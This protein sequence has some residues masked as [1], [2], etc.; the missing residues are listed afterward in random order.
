MLNM[1]T[2]PARSVLRLHNLFGYRHRS[3]R[4]R[5]LDL[6]VFALQLRNYHKLQEIAKFHVFSFSN[7]HQIGIC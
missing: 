3:L 5:R 1:L 7:T 2:T 4:K 6:C